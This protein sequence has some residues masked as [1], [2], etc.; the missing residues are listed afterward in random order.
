M[1]FFE[2]ITWRGKN[3]TAFGIFEGFKVYEELIIFRMVNI[4]IN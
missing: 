1:H 2:G 4:V 3:W